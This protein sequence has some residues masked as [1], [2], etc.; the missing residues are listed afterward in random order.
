MLIFKLVTIV[1]VFIVLAY[2]YMIKPRTRR[3]KLLHPFK[4]QLIA[5]RGLFNNEGNAPENS[6]AA[7]QAAVDKGYGIEL[8]VLITKDS[9]LVVFHDETLERM[10]NIKANIAD[11]T[12]QELSHCTLL[13]SGEKIPLLS[14][15]LTMVNGS[16][17]LLIEIKA[18][19]SSLHLHRD[20]CVKSAHLLRNYKG[21][22]T[23]QSFNPTIVLWFKKNMPQ[24]IRGQLATDYSKDDDNLGF[25]MN[26][27][28]THLLLNFITK[29]DYIAYN[30]KYANQ[31]S[32]TICKKLFHPI[33]VGWTIRNQEQ[34]ET[35]KK[36]CDIIIFDSF[37][38]DEKKT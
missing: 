8:D 33:N 29:P 21:L 10:C 20:L 3:R 1:I 16:V 22:Y 31:F 13:N 30:Q 27:L 5:H 26:F 9:Q 36:D 17:P 15:V 2:V 19:K 28:C 4:K 34:F 25:L 6:L 14:E 32:Y 7:F 37:I 12:Y 11:L 24:M 18:D 35:A 38:P 23:V